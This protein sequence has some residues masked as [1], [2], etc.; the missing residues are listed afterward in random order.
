MNN[1]L[2]PGPSPKA[3]RGA[4]RG[5]P[6]LSP[7]ERGWGRG[8]GAE[9]VTMRIMPHGRAAHDALDVSQRRQA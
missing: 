2:S 9:V 7:W 1:T 5:A 4:V 6:L 8:A 3:E